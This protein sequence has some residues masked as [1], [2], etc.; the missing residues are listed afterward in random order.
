MAAWAFFGCLALA[1]VSSA[2]ATALAVVWA[3]LW[4]ALGWVGTQRS[5]VTASMRAGA[6]LTSMF[7][8]IPVY[9]LTVAS[10][11]LTLIPSS[12]GLPMFA[13]LCS[14]APMFFWSLTLK[15]RRRRRHSGPMLV[16]S[17]HHYQSKAPESA[18]PPRTSQFRR[19][20]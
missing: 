12:A 2:N 7:L 9:L 19:A 4:I 17:W 11:W 15:N 14:S 13:L 18:I 8:P 5:G 6:I 1:D 16:M 3:A 20:I 10:A